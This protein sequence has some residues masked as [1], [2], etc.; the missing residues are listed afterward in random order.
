MKKVLVIWFLSTIIFSFAQSDC[1]EIKVSYNSGVL[2][3]FQEDTVLYLDVSFDPDKHPIIYV[4]VAQEMD[5]RPVSLKKF[6]VTKSG[7]ISVPVKFLG[8]KTR[9]Q[10]LYIQITHSK[11]EIEKN[12]FKINSC[13]N[14]KIQIQKGILVK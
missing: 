6:E 4:R 13:V 5:K 1:N 8:S 12:I 7:Q 2:Y 3:S 9:E 10:Y 14:D 11:E